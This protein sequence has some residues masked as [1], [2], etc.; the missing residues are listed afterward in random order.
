MNFFKWLTDAD[1]EEV[2]NRHELASAHL[3]G[4]FHQ[5][6]CYSL[7]IILPSEGLYENST[8]QTASQGLRG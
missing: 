1:S 2:Y 7:P 4:R 3:R 6:I 5:S 8:A